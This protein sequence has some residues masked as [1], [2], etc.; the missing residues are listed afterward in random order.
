MWKYLTFV[1]ASI[2]LLIGLTFSYFFVNG[3]Y[4]KSTD[5]RRL[6]ELSPS[7]KDLILGEMRTLLKAV[8][9]V[10][11]ALSHGDMKA[12]SDSARS[13]GMAMAADVNP[14]LMAKLPLDFKELGMGTHA[15]FDKLAKEIDD[16]AN[17]QIIL[18]RL[19][20]ITLRCIACHEANRLATIDNN[21]FRIK[22]SLER[23]A[24]ALQ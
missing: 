13:A 23:K 19:S 7:E 15:E 8:N 16:G 24:Y 21:R 4:T 22:F 9:G 5:N 11:M 2:L 6:I 18:T 17:H 10:I 1:L 12:A 3:I 20:Q 14:L